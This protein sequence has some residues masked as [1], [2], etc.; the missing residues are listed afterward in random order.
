M[1]GVTPAVYRATV[2]VGFHP[3]NICCD[4]CWCMID[5]PHCRGR[6]VCMLTQE[7]IHY[8]KQIGLRCPLEEYTYET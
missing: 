4:G 2:T 6:K 7:I 3:D 1:N 8:P 5:D